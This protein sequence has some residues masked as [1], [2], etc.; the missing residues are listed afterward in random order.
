MTYLYFFRKRR[1]SNEGSRSPSIKKAR[2][3]SPALSTHS[4]K[5]SR[6]IPKEREPDIDNHSEKV[7]VTSVASMD[8]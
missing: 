2:D 4:K 6:E 3:G 7:I 5:S 8:E 1:A